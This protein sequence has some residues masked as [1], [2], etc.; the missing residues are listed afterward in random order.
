MPLVLFR[1]LAIEIAVHTLNAMRTMS[2]TCECTHGVR[3]VDCEFVMVAGV[4]RGTNV[5]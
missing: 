3:G 1:S 4:G 5:L 2:S